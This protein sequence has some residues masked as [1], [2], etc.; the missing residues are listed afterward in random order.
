[1]QQAILSASV[2]VFSWWL[3]CCRTGERNHI[4]ILSPYAGETYYQELIICIEL[5]LVRKILQIFRGGGGRKHFDCC[6]CPALTS[7]GSSVQSDA[8]NRACSKPTS[9]NIDNSAPD[10]ILQSPGCQRL[11]CLCSSA[12]SS[13][14]FCLRNSTSWS[15]L[16]SE[17]FPGL[18]AQGFC[19]YLIAV[20]AKFPGWIHL[21]LMKCISLCSLNSPFLLSLL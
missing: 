13:R 20:P 18:P 4:S 12:V 16:V 5:T 2:D 10:K 8:E 19:R 3:F 1:M 7:P 6:Q 14:I 11:L 9:L 21:P 15:N 17:L